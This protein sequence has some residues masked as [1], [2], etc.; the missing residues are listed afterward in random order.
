MDEPSRNK[1]KEVPRRLTVAISQ[2]RVG[3]SN[4]NQREEVRTAI[5]SG[6]QRNILHDPKEDP[7]TDRQRKNRKA[8]SRILRRFVENQGLDLVEG[9][10]PSET[11]EESTRIIS[12]RYGNSGHSS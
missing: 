3:N 12:T 5:T 10:A 11:V 8:K 9:S 1:D 6:K 7:I 2:E 4:R